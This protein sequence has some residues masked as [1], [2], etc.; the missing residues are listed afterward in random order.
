MLKSLVEELK[1]LLQ[2]KKTYRR[3]SVAEAKRIGDRLGIDWARVPIG[4]FR[5]GLTVEMEHGK[6]N[7]ATNVT[8]DDLLKTG[9]IAWAH[10]RED[11]RYYTRLR[12]AG[13]KDVPP[14]T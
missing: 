4:E 8:N 12:R 14:T 1:R 7:M 9:K 3:F 5:S 11:P 10:L 6:T 13:V 2:E